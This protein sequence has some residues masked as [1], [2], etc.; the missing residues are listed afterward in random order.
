MLTTMD[1]NEQLIENGLNPQGI[2][3]DRSYADCEN[4]NCERDE[5]GDLR[6]PRIRLPV[7]RSGY[8]ENGD[9]HR[10]IGHH[11]WQ[12]GYQDG[13]L[14][15]AA[16]PAYKDNDSDSRC[17]EAKKLPQLRV[18]WGPRY[19]ISRLCSFLGLRSLERHVRFR[20][21]PNTSASRWE[22]QHLKKH[23]W[24]HETSVPATEKCQ[25]E[26]FTVLAKRWR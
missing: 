5:Q 18:G 7:Q 20:L 9:A 19:S 21:H 8:P 24:R 11:G 6:A 2:F 23:A 15:H 25:G 3:R 1:R 4:C 14:F 26:V 12:A 10:T 22:N 13:E 16:K 17:T